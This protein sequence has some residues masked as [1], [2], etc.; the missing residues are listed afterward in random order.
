MKY[1]GEERILLRLYSNTQGKNE[2]HLHFRITR[3]KLD[4]NKTETHNTINYTVPDH[5]YVAIVFI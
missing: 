5:N 4:E 1:T 3:D 2:F